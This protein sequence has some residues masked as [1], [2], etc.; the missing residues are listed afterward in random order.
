MSRTDKIA[1]VFSLLAVLV[2]AA[3]AIGIYEK[4]PQ[5]EDEHA[6]L[7]QAR[8]ITNGQ[9][10]IPS[11]PQPQS[12][13]IHFIVDYR[14]QRSSKYPLGWPVL[15]SFGV[16][17]SA[18]WLINP[19]L[20]GLAV[21]LTYRLGQKLLGGKIAL[22]AAGL[23]VS[24]PLFLTYS[25]SMLSHTWGLVLSLIF[26]ISWLD[27]VDETNPSRCG[28]PTLSAGFSLG[29]L[30]LSRPWTAI[31]V[32]VPFAIH[33]IMLL[34]RASPTI[35]KRI[36]SVG[37]IAL[38]VGSLHFLWQYALTGDF[39]TNPYLLW[40]PYDKIGF[41]INHGAAAGGHTLRQG[42]ANTRQSLKVASHDLFG[43]GKYTCV[44]S[45]IGLW[46]NRRN[47]K[48][49]LAASVFFSLVIVY[50][51]YWVSGPR[52][53]YEGLYSLTLSS[54]AGIAWLAGW[55][56][57]QKDR[58]KV[59]SRKAVIQSPC[60]HPNPLPKGAPRRA[61]FTNGTASSPSGGGLRWGKKTRLVN[62][63]LVFILL[64]AAM[65]LSATTYTPAR[66]HEIMNRYGFTQTTLEPF[67]SAATQKLA[68]A[69]IIVHAVQWK[70]YGAFLYLED[71]GLTTPFIFAWAA[72]DEDPT[73]E[74]P[75]HFPQ[76]AI[77]HYYPNEPGRLYSAP[78]P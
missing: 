32:A 69:L 8:L 56:P 77:Y 73:S 75:P 6:L 44:L 22:L 36:L 76:R 27:A 59:F 65:L 58:L 21:W 62:G 57:R 51:A 18:P 48:M 40:W 41:G 74:L 55:L 72:P 14:G 9:I 50:M 33:G 31:G 46:A 20:A 35:K 28:L 42:W 78:R 68:P 47:R 54:A 7:W 67:R 29:V 5:L 70:D 45:I 37:A 23:T 53:F 49:W 38:L 10:T 26:A 30:A 11:P 52:Y 4:L 3:V 71:P 66:L 39:R 16:C 1:L 63:N 64:I 24:S 60:P 17:I 61:C 13:F 25:G 12:F 43:W 2:S 15:L 19:L 34:L